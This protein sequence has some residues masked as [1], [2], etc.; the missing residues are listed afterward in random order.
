MQQAAPKALPRLPI[1]ELLGIRIVS[2]TPDRVVGTMTIGAGHMNGEGTAQG[3]V[4]T[5]FADCLAGRGAALNLPE[6]WR[7]TT[8]ETKTN[9]FAPGRDGVIDGEATPIH[10]GR[11]TSVWQ[12]KVRDG[13]GRDIALVLQ[14]QIS[15]PRDAAVAV[16]PA[17]VIEAAVAEPAAR[18]R[19]ATVARQRAKIF[20]AATDVI[21]EKGFDRA[22]VREI[23]EAAGMPVAT[24]YQYVRNKEDILLLIFETYLPEVRAALESAVLGPGSAT[25]RLEAGVVALMRCFDRYRSQIKLMFQETK[26]LN[27]AARRRTTEMVREMA[28]LWERLMTEGATSGEFHVKHPNIVSHLI[29]MMCAIWPLRYWAVGEH[30]SEAVAKVIS[31]VLLGGVA[32][33]M[34]PKR[35]RTAPKRE[36]QR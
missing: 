30:G 25:E 7:S 35:Q 21:E 22:N 32:A 3:G 33:G 8:I 17:A 16:E 14:T 34:A 24:M 23:A 9:F 19:A 36:H 29:P 12:T 27:P 20:Q 2:A 28:T 18:S 26:S 10:L 13:T 11:T 6:G 15:L 5:V 4:L 31:Q 1:H